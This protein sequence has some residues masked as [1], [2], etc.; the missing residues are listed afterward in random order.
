MLINFF[1]LLAYTNFWWRI[2]LA[3]LNW[4][5][6]QTLT[7]FKFCL[8]L[9]KKSFLTFSSD[10]SVFS[11]G[12]TLGDTLRGSDWD[13]RVIFE[14]I[15][16]THPTPVKKDD[17]KENSIASILCWPQSYPNFKMCNTVAMLKIWEL[18]N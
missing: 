14:N 3:T 18:Q 10:S 5:R 16:D 4:E 11:Q 12:I 15:C 9:L 8:V 2:K 1:P 6:G 13:A 7:G 17:F